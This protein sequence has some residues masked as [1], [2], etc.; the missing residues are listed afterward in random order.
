MISWAFCLAIKAVAIAAS[1]PSNTI[2]PFPIPFSST[3]QEPTP[4]L[5][6]DE[7]TANFMQ[8]DIYLTFNV[9]Y[10]KY[11]VSLNTTI[12]VSTTQSQDL[13]VLLYRSPYEQFAKE[14]VYR[15]FILHRR[16]KFDSM[17][18]MEPS[19]IRSLTS[20]TSRPMV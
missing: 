14:N 10:L 4:P 7:F 8:V 1:N 11:P 3:F 2:N 20:T 12:L 19:S 16:I 18:Q 15:L 17:V 5:I 13:L 6:Q 9:L